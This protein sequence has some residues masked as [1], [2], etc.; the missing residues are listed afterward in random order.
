MKYLFIKKYYIVNTLLSTKFRFSCNKALSQYLID[1]DAYAIGL[2][3]VVVTH[4]LKS[5]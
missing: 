5:N 3:L 2:L 1:Y 4:S